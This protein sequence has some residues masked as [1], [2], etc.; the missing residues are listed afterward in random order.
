MSQYLTVND[1]DVPTKVAD[2]FDA[3]ENWGNYDPQNVVVEQSIIGELYRGCVNGKR[4]LVDTYGDSFSEDHYDNIEQLQNAALPRTNTHRPFTY[5]NDLTV[6]HHDHYAEHV[7]RVIVVTEN[8]RQ[9]FGSRSGIVWAEPHRS[10]RSAKV[11][12]TVLELAMSLVD[13]ENDINT[14]EQFDTALSGWHS[15]M[16]KSE[17]SEKINALSNGNTPDHFDSSMYPYAV[18]FGDTRNVC[19]VNASVYGT[20]SFQTAIKKEF[21]GSRAAPGGAGFN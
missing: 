13:A 16:E 1:K 4:H 15:S 17:Q 3:A 8:G 5:K 12:D 20:D 19:A 11:T 14:P 10:D 18:V 21:E 2:T 9:T 7:T 6:V